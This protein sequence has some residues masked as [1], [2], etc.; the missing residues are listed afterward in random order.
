MVR[1][2][3][4]LLYVPVCVYAF[5]ARLIA[6]ARSALWFAWNDAVT[7]HDAMLRTWRRGRFDPEDWS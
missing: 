5:V 6:E 4:I 2:L 1:A 3:I 7:E